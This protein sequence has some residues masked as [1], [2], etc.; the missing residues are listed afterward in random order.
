MRLLPFLAVLLCAP[1]AAQTPY[2]V[3]YKDFAFSNTTSKGSKSLLARVFYPAKTQAPDQPLLTRTGGWPTIMF[4]HGYQKYGNQYWELAY[5]A[6][7]TGRVIVL[8]DTAPDDLQLQIDDAIAIYPS[9]VAANKDSKSFLYG[10]MRTDRMILS[11]H[12][13]GAAHVFHVLADNPGYI[14]GISYGPFL[15]FDL[16][17]TQSVTPKVK[18]PVLILSGTGEKI[19]PWQQHALGAFNQLT[20]FEGIKLLYLLGAECN[21]YNVIAYQLGTTTD[22]ECFDAIHETVGGFVDFIVDQDPQTLEQVC[23]EASRQRKR[24]YGTFI[25]VVEPYEWR[26]GS[27]SIGK[28]AR[29]Q[30]AAKPG[31]AFHMLAF[32]NPVALPTT[33]GILRCDPISI[34]FLGFQPVPTSGHQ[35]LPML[36]PNLPGLKGLPFVFQV[37]APGRNGDRLGNAML[38]PID[39]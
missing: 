16:K 10:A 21:H 1:L 39:K 12:S 19:T 24:W 13:T 29:I 33:W 18:V 37:L 27:L 5:W 31:Q 11:G 36:I 7:S 15:G 8:A 35:V 6:A 30:V 34:A 14:A 20:S 3:S 38:F 22:K 28:L 26:T 2:P 9:L 23:G 32:G 4:M 17:Y 25:D